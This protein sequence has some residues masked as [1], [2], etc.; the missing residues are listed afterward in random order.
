MS[1][2]IKKREKELVEEKDRVYFQKVE[3]AFKKDWEIYEKVKY[4]YYL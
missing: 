2:T 1:E 3:E 4:F